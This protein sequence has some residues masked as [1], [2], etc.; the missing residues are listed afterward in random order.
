MHL[1]TQKI[2]KYWKSFSLGFFAILLVSCGA[3]TSAVKDVFTVITNAEFSVITSDN[4][5]P[6]LNGRPSPI[7]FRVYELKSNSA[8]V[9]AD[10]FALYDTGAGELAADYVSHKDWL[11]QPGETLK[12]DNQLSEQTR[13][14]GVMAAYRDINNSVWRRV[15]EITPDEDLK[16]NITL[17]NNELK[18]TTK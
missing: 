9:N 4:V 7:L 14:L 18:I 11:L 3:T 6:D 2:S 5:N 1:L 16:L 17:S 15:I 8:F 12:T 13:Y 10:F